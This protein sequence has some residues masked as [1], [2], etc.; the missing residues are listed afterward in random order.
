MDE[1]A[2]STEEKRSPGKLVLPSLVLSRFAIAGLEIL[3]GLLLIEIGLTFGC[4]VGVVGQI[5][6]QNA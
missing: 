5:T 2:V 1:M 4:S 6:R 3:T